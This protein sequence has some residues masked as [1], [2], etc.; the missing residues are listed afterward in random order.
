MIV[1]TKRKPPS[2]KFSIITLPQSHIQSGTFGI[3]VYQYCQV[4]NDLQY[5][6]LK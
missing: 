6:L 4:Y 2:D 5:D 3:P 1:G